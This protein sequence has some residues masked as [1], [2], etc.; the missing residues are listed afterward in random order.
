MEKST[1]NTREGVS[2][3]RRKSV[4]V[5]LLWKYDPNCYSHNGIDWNIGSVKT[6]AGYLLQ[7]RLG[8]VLR[9]FEEK[10]K[11]EN[12]LKWAMKYWK[13]CQNAEKR[14][15]RHKMKAINHPRNFRTPNIIMCLEP[16]STLIRPWM[17][18]YL[19]DVIYKA[20]LGRAFYACVYCLLLRFQRNYV[21]WLKPR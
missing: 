4:W 8:K 2:C 10:R 14:G 12:E 7:G 6:R 13:L 9:A 19:L 17:K 11:V 20:A 1:V 16:K 3:I 15:K 18:H 5:M 21:G